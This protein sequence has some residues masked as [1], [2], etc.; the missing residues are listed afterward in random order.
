[1]QRE[2]SLNTTAISGLLGIRLSPAGTAKILKALGFEVKNKKSG[3]LSVKAPSFRQ[4][5]KTEIDLAEEIA[6]IYGYENIPATLPRMA[7]QELTINGTRGLVSLIKNTLVALGLSE[8]VTY[9]LV[10]K[11]LLRAAKSE[12]LNPAEISNPLSA[13]QEILRPAIIPSLL[14][15]VA[16]NLNQK[17][18]YVN[19]FEIAS[20]FSFSDNGAPEERL[21][22]GIALC[23][24]KPYFISEA[25]GAVREEMGL[26][27]LKGVL[28]ALFSRLGIKEDP[29]KQ[30]FGAMLAPEKEILDN[31]DIKNK[32]V[33]VSQIDLDKLFSSVNLTKKFTSLP[34]YPGITRDISL[35]LKEEIPTGQVLAAIKE[36][37]GALLKEAKIADFYKGRQIPQ[38]FKSLTISCFY[39]SDE[40]T[41]AEAQINPAHSLICAFLAEKFQAKIR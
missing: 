40:R 17:Q 35:I 23:G 4:D 31:F 39:R 16:Y 15:C 28:E 30:T 37:A 13:E 29:E 14:K 27:H 11:K 32:D 8:V 36:K 9:S 6:R 1:M 3:I 12:P 33:V 38:G 22:L 19:I 2:I 5:I 24:I 41:L 25:S 34:L 7:P 20:V 18:E 21:V 10:D 26:L